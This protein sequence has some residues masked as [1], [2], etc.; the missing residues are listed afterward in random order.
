MGGGHAAGTGR[1]ATT[2][3]PASWSA[4]RILGLI[5]DVANR[6][7]EPPRR[8]RNGRWRA[9]GVRE[10]VSIVV[11]VE[12]DGRVHTGFPTAGP[13]VVRNP[14]TAAD[15]ANPTVADVTESRVSFYA[16]KLLAQLANRLPGWE[17]A[18]YHE[19]YVAGEWEELV[20]VLAAHLVAER[21]PLTV[22]ELADFERLLNTYDIPQPGCHFLNDRERVLAALQPGSVPR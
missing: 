13:G 12:P 6:P 9:G 4:S 16:E 18:H 2:E 19:L 22:D 7:D 10:G 1:R 3:F 8:L 20:D 21:L 5:T 15:P 11:L 17:L 14:D